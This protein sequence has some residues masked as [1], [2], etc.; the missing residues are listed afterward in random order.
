MAQVEFVA[1]V[2]AI[3]SNFRV[4]PAVGSGETLREAQDRLGELMADSQPR[5]TLQ[6]NRPRDVRLRWTR[7]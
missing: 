2:M 4:A 3:F 7:R 6:M 1:V 5:I